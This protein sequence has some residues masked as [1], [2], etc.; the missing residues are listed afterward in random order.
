MES[1][2]ES[3]PAGSA[4]WLQLEHAD[5]G[6]SRE[7]PSWILARWREGSSVRTAM[8]ARCGYHPTALLVDRGA[9]DAF[10]AALAR[11]A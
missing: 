4:A 1:W 7:W 2:L 10:A 8:L 3:S 11:R 9:A 5:E 6:A